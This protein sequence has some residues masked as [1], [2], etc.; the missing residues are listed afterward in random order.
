LSLAF[1]RDPERARRMIEL[2]Q[3]EASRLAQLVRDL[4]DLARLEEEVTVERSRQRVD[5]AGMVREQCAQVAPLARSRGLP[6]ACD[7]LLPAP[8]VAVPEDLRLIA[9]NLLANAVRYNRDG[10]RI[11]VTVARRGGEVVLSVSDTGIGIAAADQDRIFERFYRVDKARSRAVGGTG[12]GL[13]IVR[14]AAERH[15]GRVSVHSILGE[16][17]TFTVTLPV[18]G[19]RRR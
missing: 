15:G 10:G 7:C 9:A 2:L 12:L 1:Q 3:Q 13:S 14:H 16:G 19:A 8:V 18:E 17:S 5:F 11:E 4:L 6:L